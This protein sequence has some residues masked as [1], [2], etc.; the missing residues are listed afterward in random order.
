MLSHGFKKMLRFHQP[1]DL[2][3]HRLVPVERR[4]VEH[5]VPVSHV[6]HLKQPIVR[7]ATHLWMADQQLNRWRSNY[8]FTTDCN[9][10]SDNKRWDELQGCFR[11]RAR[12]LFY[13]LKS[14]RLIAHT[15][16]TLMR[17]YPG[18]EDSLCNVFESE[19]CLRAYLK[20][21][22]TSQEEWM[23]EQ[24]QILQALRDKGGRWQ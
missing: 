14:H 5:V 23:W 1:Y 11:N 12:K 15:V 9:V 6:A 21:P 10:K 13:P 18:A 20:T 7:D 8:R 24:N 4:T 22:W 2:Y 17:K 16:W 3:T 19:A